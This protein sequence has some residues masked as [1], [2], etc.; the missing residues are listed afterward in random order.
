MAETYQI[1]IIAR[2]HI[3]EPGEDAIEFKGRGGAT[4]LAPDP[5]KHIQDLVLGNPVL[6]QDLQQVPVRD[7]VDFLAE[8][9][10]RLHIDDN[11]FLQ[12]SFELALRA[13]GLAEPILRRVYED[14]PRL[15][16]P[17]RMTAEIDATIGLDYLDGWL[18]EFTDAQH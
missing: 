2:G 12:Q 6:L 7:I 13:G 5:H 14:L 4:F 10:K 16:D 3:I 9:G 15:F 18:R 11:V 8:A 1:P 17:L